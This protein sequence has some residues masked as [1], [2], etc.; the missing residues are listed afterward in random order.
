MLRNKR[1]FTLLEV[2][3]AMAIMSM[4]MLMLF[5]LLRLGYRAGEK[6]TRRAG[7]AQ[8]LMVVSD[9]LSWLLAGAYPYREFNRDKR[10]EVIFF[11]GQSDSVSFVTTSVDEYSDGLADKVG[12]KYLTLSLQSRGLEIH[13]RLFF[14]PEQEP[15]IQV[16]EPE[17]TSLEIN[18]L[19]IDPDSGDAQWRQDWDSSSR[20][21]LPAAVELKIS[22][23]LEGRTVQVPPLTVRLPAGGPQGVLIPLPRRTTN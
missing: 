11:E 19:D 5:S 10:K 17:A 22:V 12:L 6:G 23:E 20:D 14:D 21:Y 16:I 18:Y 8:R 1:G 13:E 7:V 9:R 3:L 2:M 15:E 4:V